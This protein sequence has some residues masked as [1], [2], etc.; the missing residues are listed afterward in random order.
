ME[1]IV[2]QELGITVKKNQIIKLSDKMG[3]DYKPSSIDGQNGYL[4]L[5]VHVHENDFKYVSLYYRENSTVGEK[6][7]RLFSF[8]ES[9][10]QEISSNDGK[11]I[12][13]TEL[14]AIEIIPA[15]K[16][17]EVFL[18]ENQVLDDNYFL[19]EKQLIDDLAEFELRYDLGL[20]TENE[21]NNLILTEYAVDYYKLLKA[22]W[23]YMIPTYSSDTPL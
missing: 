14:F 2:I 15:I 8:T 22:K 10:I 9:T 6:A 23:N 11:I 16:Y 21:K 13:Y 20:I 12:V 19:V 17:K 4:I 3:G 18:K 5:P 1:Q 7:R